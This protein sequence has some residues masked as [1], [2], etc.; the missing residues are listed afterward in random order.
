MRISDWIGI[1]LAALGPVCL[2]LLWAADVIRPGSFT[3]RPGR[4]VGAWPAWF[5]AVCAATIFCMQAAG[6]GLGYSVMRERPPA[7]VQAQPDQP[8]T[9]RERAGLAIG[10]ALAAGVTGLVLLRL[11]A[12]RTPVSPAE[13]G[14][15]ARVSGTSVGMGL[16]G[17]ALAY[18]VVQISGFAGQALWHFL[19]PEAPRE[20]GH[21]TL[22]TI[23]E[24]PGTLAAAALTIGAVV[25]A[26]IVEELMFRVFLQSALLRLLGRTWP[27][28]LITSVLFALIH[29]GGGV[30]GREGY[31]LFP[32]FVLGVAMGIAYERSRNAVVPMLMH[33]T[34]NLVN[35]AF[36]I[37]G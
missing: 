33:A 25:G 14:L 8:L 29:L 24:N 12:E 20:I 9:P 4:D 32:L 31:L 30:S 10:G 17:I 34:F 37:L 2:V 23:N 11:V 26:P 36:T 35:V 21:E 1:G 19:S 15:R 28:I 27:A 18:P 16:L 13:T 5:W 7:T 22:R 6:G 3:R